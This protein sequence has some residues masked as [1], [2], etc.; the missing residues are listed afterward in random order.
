[1]LESLPYLGAVETR[2][3]HRA[4]EGVVLHDRTAVHPGY[5]LYNFDSQRRALLVDM[6]G[7]TVHE[8][9]GPESGATWA[10][11]EL[12]NDGHLFVIATREA[13][14]KLDW[15][16]NVV[17]TV[18]VAGHHDLA[19]AENG[20]VYVLVVQERSI[21]VGGK[22]LTIKDN[23]VARI[24]ANGKV[25]KT[26]WLYPTLAR[27]ELFR[28]HIQRWTVPSP[29]KQKGPADPFHVNTLE[30]LAR[31]RPGLW[32]KGDLLIAIRNMNTLAV[33]SRASGRLIWHWG[34]GVLDHPHHPSL[35]DN[36]NLLVFDNGLRRK[37]S[38][39]L[40]IDPKSGDIVWRYE[41]SE[42]APFYSA[43]RG[44]CQK[45]ANGNVLITESEQARAFEVTRE[46][47]IVW[48]FFGETL[49]HA[50]H[51]GKQ[52]PIY[53]LTRLERD[54]IDRVRDRAASPLAVGGGDAKHE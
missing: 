11:V 2:S 30:I 50:I 49:P 40:E 1:M 29:E 18:P 46:G 5:S 36:G 31:D 20:D 22:Q 39:V 21:D 37:S 41:G 35:L 6:D 43:Y 9:N 23:G 13:V 14:S 38:R 44:G 53:R 17:W 27:H 12:A 7:S 54:W 3:E 51:K 34:D 45:L 26:W 25:R 48:E 28:Q 15:N 24:S 19:L 16:S 4:K 33:V 52:A 8:W 10:H 47:R 32:R 42:S